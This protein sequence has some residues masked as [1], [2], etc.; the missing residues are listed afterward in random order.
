MKKIK[1][2]IFTCVVIIL[3]L[4]TAIIALKLYNQKK[5][6]D[7]ENKKNEIS[8]YIKFETANYKSVEDVVFYENDL[9]IED[10]LK[11]NFKLIA[12]QLK[13]QYPGKCI[14]YLR[15]LGSAS[16]FDAKELYRCMQISNGQKIDDTEMN[17]LIYENNK[18]EFQLL[19]G[20]AWKNGSIEDVKIT[21]EQAEQITIEYLVDNPNDYKE[22]KLGYKSNEKC[23]CELYYYNSKKCWKM[24][25]A[26][27]NSFIIIDASTG[28]ILKKY[29]FSGIYVD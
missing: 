11:E 4:L 28:K 29:F 16:M 7:L 3:I 17:V 15:N 24:Q 21:Q 23:T 19:I 12:N 20:Q 27:G 18:V 10:E 2:A 5:I 8:N 22:L 1:V 26:T 6:R 14:L 25:F 13:I 9:E